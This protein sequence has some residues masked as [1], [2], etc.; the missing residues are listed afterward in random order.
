M[1]KPVWLQNHQYEEEVI[2][3]R[4]RRYRGK[5]AQKVRCEEDGIASS[6]TLKSGSFG[7]FEEVGKVARVAG[8]SVQWPRGSYTNLE[9]MPRVFKRMKIEELEPP[10]PRKQCSPDLSRARAYLNFEGKLHIER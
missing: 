7:G 3:I 10:R 1:A 9:I 6:L 8:R 2:S 4:T 5:S